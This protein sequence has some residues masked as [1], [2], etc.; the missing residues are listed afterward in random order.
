MACVQLFRLKDRKGAEFCLSPT[1]EEEITQLVASEVSSY[2]QLPLR[3]YQIGRKYRDEMRPRAGL[4]RG[5]EFVMKDLYTFDASEQEAQQTYG[6][7][8]EAYRRL[9]TRIGLAY[10]V[11]CV[12]IVHPVLWY[13]AEE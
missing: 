12:A 8:L 7:V 9:F 11:V 10:E 1:H 3:V 2:R 4:L 5:R 6:D 13:G